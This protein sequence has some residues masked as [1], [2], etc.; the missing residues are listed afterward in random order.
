M[1]PRVCSIKKFTTKLDAKIEKLKL[2]MRSTQAAKDN[3]EKL[4]ITKLIITPNLKT[5]GESSDGDNQSISPASTVEQQK[6]AKREARK[7]KWAAR[8]TQF[9]QK[10]NKTAKA[11]AKPLLIIL[12]AIFGPVLLAIDLV[13]WLIALVVKLVLSILVLLFAPFYYCFTW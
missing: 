4:V 1:S 13:I 10:A 9:K 11:I 6:K 2:K 3:E 5:V 12:G 8:R 7:A